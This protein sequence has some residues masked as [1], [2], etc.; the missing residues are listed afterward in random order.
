MEKVAFVRDE[1]ANLAWALQ[2]LPQTPQPTPVAS[3]TGA[4]DLTYVP[5]TLPP[6]DRVPMVLTETAAG[7]L[8]VRGRLTGKKTGPAGDLLSREFKLRDE[9]LPDE[10]LILER[11][12]ELGRTP[13]GV[14]HMWVSQVKSTGTRLPSSGLDYDQIG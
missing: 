10:G 6:D 11:R 1:A 12:Y 3:S 14:L 9:E 4:G 2:V 5:I 7:R 8:L 13:D